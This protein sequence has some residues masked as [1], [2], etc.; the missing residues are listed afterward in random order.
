M[1]C[2]DNK[3]W[4]CPVSIIPGQPLNPDPTLQISPNIG[5]NC[6]RTTQAL[7]TSQSAIQAMINDLNR[8]NEALFQSLIACPLMTALKSSPFLMAS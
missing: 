7:I 3:E 8:V 5:L 4:Q 1:R 2:C 6:F